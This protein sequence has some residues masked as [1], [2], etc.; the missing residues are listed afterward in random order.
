MLRFSTG[1]IIAILAAVLFGCYLAMPNLLTA[2]QRAAL[3]QSVP[4][5]VPSWIVPTQAI[6]LGLDLQGG[7]HVLLEVDVNDLIRGRAGLINQLRDDVRRIIREERASLEGGIQTT[8]RGVQLRIRQADDRSRVLPKLRD[9]SQPISNA[10][11]GQTGARN[12][13]VA[14]TS[15]GAIQLTYTDEGINERVRRAIDQAIEVLRRR[16]DQ[17]GTTEPV[18]QRQGADRILVQVPG[19]QDPQRLKDL[20]GQTAKLEFRMIAQPGATDVDML[21]SAES[22]GTVPVERQVIVGGEDLIDAQPAFD[23][24]TNQP[25]VNFRFNI[26]GAQRFG[27][28]TTRNLGRPLAI[29]LDNR[30]ISAPVI[31]SPIT[32]GAG[33]ISGSFTVEAV[34]NLAILL[35]AGALP[36]KL[37]IVEERTVG[38]GL[39]QDSI[40]AG[41]IA[42]IAGAALVAVFMVLA[43]GFF[44]VL[45]TVALLVNVV[46]M[47]GLLSAL[48]ATLTLPGIAGIVL[49][50]GMAVDSNVLIY[51]RVREE[52]RL[53][54]SAAS[55]LDAGFAR[56]LTTIID[57]N[58][59][60]FIAAAVLY[61]LGTGPVRGFA[62]TLTLGIITTVF[63]AYML[64]RLMVAMWFRIARPQRIA[65]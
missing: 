39:G 57:A 15:D 29:V 30:V 54:R 31:Q 35:R 44:G 2:E 52:Q 25:I 58:L 18:I 26:R 61:F 45:A 6:V 9:L 7:S 60:T 38:P 24:Q 22:G 62:V 12:I 48:G 64:T 20:L 3:K 65:M 47:F 51:E 36:A 5:W 49:T 34:N 50:I 55:S 32:Q 23:S 40:R 14:E 19:L 28:A 41:V 33:Q 16:I 53:G 27:E 8:P 59:T 11:I 46:L 43:Y 56:A 4:A 42:C 1:K 37:T 17:L 10:I 63:T 21:P 13:D